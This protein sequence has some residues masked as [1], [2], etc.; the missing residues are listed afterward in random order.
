MAKNFSDL[1]NATTENAKGVKD[2]LNMAIKENKAFALAVEEN[3][4]IKLVFAGNPAFAV[5]AATTLLIKVVTP[6]ARGEVGTEADQLETLAEMA[7]ASERFDKLIPRC[8]EEADGVEITE[9][10]EETPQKS[11]E[12]CENAEGKRTVFDEIKE[13]VKD[14]DAEKVSGCCVLINNDSREASVFTS[15]KAEDIPVAVASLIAQAESM[16]MP[17]RTVVKK[18]R[19]LLDSANVSV[20]DNRKGANE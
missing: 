8:D 20:K 14:A 6:A 4:G 2:I 16:G 18:A 7:R 11:M 15:L 3:D 13:F 12:K 10:C 1:E 19:E 9:K 17:E 5:R